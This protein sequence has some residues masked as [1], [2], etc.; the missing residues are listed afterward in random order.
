MQLLHKWKQN[1]TKLNEIT[2][3]IESFQAIPNHETSSFKNLSHLTLR[4]KLKILSN[5]IKESEDQVRPS[6]PKTPKT[7]NQFKWTQSPGSVTYSN[8]SLFITPPP[9]PASPAKRSMLPKLIPL[10]KKPW[11]L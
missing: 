4:E 9:S 5:K 8:T 10:R 7:Q 1:I 11:Y 6:T 3:T 2:N